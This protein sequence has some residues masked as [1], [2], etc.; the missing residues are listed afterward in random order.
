MTL[1]NAFVILWVAFCAFA[2]LWP[3]V[4]IARG[5]LR[6]KIRR[7]ETEL[8]ARRTGVW[9]TPTMR[10]LRAE[11]AAEAE[12]QKQRAAFLARRDHRIVVHTGER[13][14]RVG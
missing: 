5:H 7:A 11:V 2:L 4:V 3:L 8:K 13:V 6:Q 9:P 14:R 1:A 12:R 10:D